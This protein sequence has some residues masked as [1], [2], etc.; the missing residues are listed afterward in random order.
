MVDS[1]PRKITLSS[2]R[3]EIVVVLLF[4]CCAISHAQ[5]ILMSNGTTNACSGTFYDSGGN[6]GQY[7]N[8]EN[9]TYTICPSGPGQCVRANLHLFQYGIE[10]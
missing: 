10:F 2:F 4:F 3:C 5:T 1:T 9:F 8:N 6:A 7:F